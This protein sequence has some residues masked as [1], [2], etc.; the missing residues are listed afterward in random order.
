M[1]ITTVIVNTPPEVWGGLTWLFEP[2]A[3][4]RLF[5]RAQ[6]WVVTGERYRTKDRIR[7]GVVDSESTS[8]KRK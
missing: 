7:N 1:T 2:L 4:D 8:A 6:T 5:R 3:R